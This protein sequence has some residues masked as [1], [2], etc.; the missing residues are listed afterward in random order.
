MTNVSSGPGRA[1][2]AAAVTNDEYKKYE[3]IMIGWVKTW[4]RELPQRYKISHPYSS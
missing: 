4:Q 3:L 1:A 2:P